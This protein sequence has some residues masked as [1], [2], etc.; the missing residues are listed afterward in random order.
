VV[1]VCA[2]AG[3]VDVWGVVDGWVDE[4]NLPC[5]QM[6]TP[7][8]S[9]Q[10]ALIRPCSHRLEPPHGL[11]RDRRR[12]CSHIEDSLIPRATRGLPCSTIAVA[13]AL[14]TAGT[15]TPE[16][17]SPCSSILCLSCEAA[18]LTGLVEDSPSYPAAIIGQ[19]SIAV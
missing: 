17:E 7:P 6:D 3:G 11:Q 4:G 14:A 8:Q 18:Q 15:G 9:L 10:C 5:S 12:L 16:T 19:Y 13:S 2:R 1:C